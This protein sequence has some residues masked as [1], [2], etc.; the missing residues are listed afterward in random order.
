MNPQ[1]IEFTN[2]L[3]R[4]AVILS[5]SVGLFLVFREL[6]CWYWKINEGIALLTQIR[7]LLVRSESRTLIETGER[8]VCRTC[9]IALPA[10]AVVCANGHAIAR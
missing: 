7:D 6:I 4:F 8:R 5:V 10:S 9:G 2:A 1:D 3:T